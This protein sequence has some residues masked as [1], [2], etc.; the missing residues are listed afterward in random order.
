MRIAELRQNVEEN[1]EKAKKSV[2]R[3]LSPEATLPTE[4]LLPQPGDAKAKGIEEMDVEPD[5]EALLQQAIE[6][7]KREEE[8]ERKRRKLES[9][10]PYQIE[11][12]ETALRIAT[13]LSLAS[14]SSAYVKE[15]HS[16]NFEIVRNKAS[17]SSDSAFRSLHSEMFQDSHE[18]LR[19][20]IPAKTEPRF[21]ELDVEAAE[22][23]KSFDFDAQDEQTA[24]VKKKLEKSS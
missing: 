12:E 14:S 13:E 19:K 9:D 3:P 15:K 6:A 1:V 17:S 2:K 5:D 20:T 18:C 4:E 23:L 10:N 11:D 8:T 7:S 21:D 22:V 16:W 24:A